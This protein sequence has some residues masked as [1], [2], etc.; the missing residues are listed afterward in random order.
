MILNKVAENIWTIEGDVVSFYGL[1]YPTRMTVVRLSN[2][3][4]WIHS[5]VKISNNLIDVILELGE[6]KYLI[7]PNNL[8]HLFL[9]DWVKRFPNAFSYSPPCLVKKRKDITFS[10]ELGLQ[11]EDEWSPEIDQTIFKGSPF[12]EVVFFHRNSK[13]VIFADLIENF[14][15]EFFNRWQRMVGKFAGILS[16]HGKAPLDFR[17]SFAFGKNKAKKSLSIIMEWN[18]ENIIISHGEC[19]LGGGLEFLKKSFSWV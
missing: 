9:A 15:P 14:K 6:V 4:L 1:P 19:I 3:D 13:T 18:P 12:K 5:P 2:D 16:P 10:K 7:A 17:L 11:S 8:H